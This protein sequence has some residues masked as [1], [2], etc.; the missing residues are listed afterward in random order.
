MLQLVGYSISLSAFSLYT[1]YK[2][3]D[4]RRNV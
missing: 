3:N 2:L 1:F 4:Q